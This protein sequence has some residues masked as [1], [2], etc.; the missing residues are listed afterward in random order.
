MR[1]LAPAI[2]RWISASAVHGQAWTT[3][4]ALPF[5]KYL[6]GH[7]ASPSPSPTHPSDLYIVFLFHAPRLETSTVATE[8][9]STLVCPYPPHILKSI[10]AAPRLHTPD[11]HAS[12]SALRTLPA[13]A[14]LHA[15][16]FVTDDTPDAASVHLPCLRRFHLTGSAWCAAAVARVIAG[17]TWVQS[18]G[19]LDPRPH[20]G[21][22]ATHRL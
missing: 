9:W 13:G 16:C 1:A 10:G 17:G 7:E 19:P 20:T 6:S 11:I 8:P 22:A 3:R 12:V 4:R 21:A 2:S 5:S 18:L 15:S 14:T